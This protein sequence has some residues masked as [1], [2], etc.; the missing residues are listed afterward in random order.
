M[1]I[2]TRMVRHIV[3]AVFSRIIIFVG[4]DTEDTEVAGLTRPHPIIGVT[5][6]LAQTLWGC[7]D[8]TYI[9]ISLIDREE[10]ATAFIKSIHFTLN[11][12]TAII[13]HL[14]QFLRHGINDGIGLEDGGIIRNGTQE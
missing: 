8:Q 9:V 5:S 3:L 11:A 6:I 14:H 1:S 2:L 13:N 4:I 7:I 12:F 10:I